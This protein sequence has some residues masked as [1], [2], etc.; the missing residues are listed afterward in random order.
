[1][2]LLAE[3]GELLTSD[4]RFTLAMDTRVRLTSLVGERPEGYWQ[5]LLRCAQ[6]LDLLKEHNNH[7]WSVIDPDSE[8]LG[9]T[10]SECFPALMAVWLSQTDW[11]IELLDGA[12]EETPA[13]S[14]CMNMALLRFLGVFEAGVWYPVSDLHLMA[15][16]VLARHGVEEVT[17]EF[18]DQLLRHVF[19]PLGACE[20]SHDGGSFR[21]QPGLALPPLSLL[22]RSL[23]CDLMEQITPRC[24][25]DAYRSMISRKLSANT[26]WTQVSEELARFR[27]ERRE[28]EAD[29]S[30]LK[31]VRDFSVRVATS[32]R[33]PFRDCL[34]LAR[35]GRLVPTS[36]GRRGTYVFELQSS[37]LRCDKR[38]AELSGFLTQRCCASKARVSDLLANAKA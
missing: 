8:M 7:T 12:V 25:V 30:C 19:L 37:A 20:M 6:V 11:L 4:A 10:Q 18:T 16:R 27:E 17:E 34:Y 1:M 23:K 15:T 26:A 14:P 31:I 36:E 29:D 5:G 38:Q 22:D 3:S 21:V 24:R 32:P 33:I 2:A 35:F 28:R 9:A 13:P